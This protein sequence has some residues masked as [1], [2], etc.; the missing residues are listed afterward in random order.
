MAW[1]QGFILVVTAGWAVSERT[2]WVSDRYSDEVEREGLLWGYGPSVEGV[3]D[4]AGTDSLIQRAPRAKSA[5]SRCSQ[6]G[7]GLDNPGP[8]LHKAKCVRC[9]IYAI[10]RRMSAVLYML[11]IRYIQHRTHSDIYIYIIHTILTRFRRAFNVFISLGS[12]I[13]GQVKT[14]EHL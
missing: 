8:S 11:Y 5:G 1:L 14:S 4:R 2:L 13:A 10:S 3:T 12:E 7:S 9:Y 6:Y